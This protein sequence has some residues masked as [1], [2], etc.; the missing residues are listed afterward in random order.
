[1]PLVHIALSFALPKFGAE[2]REAA[3]A[4]QKLP[5][6][7][8]LRAWVSRWHPV[9]HPKVPVARDWIVKPDAAAG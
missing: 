3:A 6:R 1:M 4:D 2:G 9:D 8:L 5:D 7:K